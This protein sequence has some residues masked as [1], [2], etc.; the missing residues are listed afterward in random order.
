MILVLYIIKHPI[1]SEGL[2][3][4]TSCFRDHL[5]IYSYPL[6]ENHGSASV[7]ITGAGYIC[8][9]VYVYMHRWLTVTSCRKPPAVEL[10]SSMFR[11]M[12]E[13]MKLLHSHMM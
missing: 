12:D 9:Y 11:T 6:S 5:Y 1:A 8:G 10:L 4:Q 3:P 2:Y 7:W 13:F